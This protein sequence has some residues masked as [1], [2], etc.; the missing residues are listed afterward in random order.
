[1]TQI[2]ISSI[3]KDDLAESNLSKRQNGI[4]SLRKLLKLHAQFGSF[5]NARG[6]FW[7]KQ[8]SNDFSKFGYLPKFTYY[9]RD[10]TVSVAG[11]QRHLEANII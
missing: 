1:M 4:M 11:N 5:T 7:S 8:F 9:S 3:R 6:L 2:R 10:F